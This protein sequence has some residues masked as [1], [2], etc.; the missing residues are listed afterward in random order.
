MPYQNNQ[1]L[2]KQVK[3]NVP[4]HGQD[5]YRKAYNNAY[6]QYENPDERR[7]DESQEEAAARVA[8]NAV[9]QE[10]EKGDDGDWHRK[11]S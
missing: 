1:S 5:I 3:N 10:Y 6:D 11:D 2:P 4:K 9:K 8:W 7:G